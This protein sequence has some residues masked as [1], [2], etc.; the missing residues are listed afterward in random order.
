MSLAIRFLPD[1]LRSVGFASLSAA[2]IGVGA[3]LT[4]PA[5][6][7][8]V[9]NVADADL[10]FSFDGINDHFFLPSAGYILLDITAN[11]TIDTGFFL[12]EGQRLYVK[13]NGVATTTGN[14][15]FSVFYGADL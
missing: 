3:A 15:Y 5:R 13:E 2:Y 10:L 6:I 9:Y 8:Y 7:I 14:V 12:A 1:T 11:K 4:R